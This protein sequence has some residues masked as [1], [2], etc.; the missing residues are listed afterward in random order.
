MESL[1]QDVKKGSE[2]HFVDRVEEIIDM[3]LRS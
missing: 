2:I 1:S 3:V